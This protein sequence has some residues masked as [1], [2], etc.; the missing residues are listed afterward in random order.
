MF[1][2]MVCFSLFIVSCANTSRLIVYNESTYA[3]LKNDKNI[4]VKNVDGHEF[5]FFRMEV[6]RTDDMYIY[7]QCWRTKKSEPENVKFVKSEVVI[8]SVQFSGSSTAN[9][10]F[11]I[12]L[13]LGVI[14]LTSRIFR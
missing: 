11:S 9:Y 10:V 8:Q 4:L 14:L 2:I 7:A 13:L 6:S 1:K 5:R 12:A 3:T